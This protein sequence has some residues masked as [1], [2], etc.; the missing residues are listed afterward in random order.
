MRVE[1]YPD[2]AMFWRDARGFLERDEI[3]NTQLLAIGSRH[4]VEPGPTP[5]AGYTVAAGGAIIAAS[6]ITTKGTVFLSPAGESLL[7]ALHDALVAEG[8]SLGDIVAEMWE[9]D[10]RPV[11]HAAFRLTPIRSARI[12]PVYTPS[13]YRR[14]GYAA[15]LVAAMSRHLL[16]QGRSPLYLYADM[17]DPTANGIYRRI[18][19]RGVAEHLHLTRDGA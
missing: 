5:P 14:R 7:H 16:E 1:R 6:L 11:S 3:G 17:N 19:F 2:V 15:A 4:A 12:A 10:G 8:R 13:H 9:V 18:G